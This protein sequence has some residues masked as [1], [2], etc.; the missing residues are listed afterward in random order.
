MVEVPLQF[1]LNDDGDELNTSA[2]TYQKIDYEDMEERHSLNSYNLAM[3]EGIPIEYVLV[4]L[5][6]PLAFVKVL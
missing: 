3:Q 2:Y 1:H 6:F 4:L 5:R